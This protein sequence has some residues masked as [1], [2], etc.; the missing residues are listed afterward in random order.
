[1]R[2]EVL[3]GPEKRSYFFNQAEYIYINCWSI[4]CA[5]GNQNIKRC[6]SL[7]KLAFLVFPNLTLNFGPFKSTL[8]I[9][10][11]RLIFW[12][13]LTRWQYV[14]YAEEGVIEVSEME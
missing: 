10:S 12:A 13:L 9:P 7:I 5:R 14:V 11:H 4:G 3:V 8:S 1:M 6:T 2:V